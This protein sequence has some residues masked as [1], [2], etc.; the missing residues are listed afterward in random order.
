M[1]DLSIYSAAA[2]ELSPT[3]YLGP[4]AISNL[5][6]GGKGTSGL[7]SLRLEEG[8]CDGGGEVEAASSLSRIMA[9]RWPKERIGLG[10]GAGANM[11]EG[12]DSIGGSGGKGI[13]GGGTGA[14]MEI[15]AVVRYAG[16]GGGVAADSSVSNGS[17]PPQMGP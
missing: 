17:S 2:D 1:H 14:G 16:C 3:S 6:R 4:R 7:S 9:A 15:L 13:R 11:G 10:G 5:F 12:G 8:S